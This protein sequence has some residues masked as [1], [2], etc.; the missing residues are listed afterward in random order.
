[1][2]VGPSFFCVARFLTP[3]PLILEHREC[4]RIKTQ[5]PSPTEHITPFTT[6]PRH[7]SQPMHDAIRLKKSRSP[8]RYV[9]TDV[10]IRQD[11]DVLTPEQR[12]T[13]YHDTRD[14]P[15][16]QESLAHFN[17]SQLESR[18]SWIPYEELTDIE[19]VGQGGVSTV[20]S[21]SYRTIKV[22]FK[23]MDPLLEREIIY[24]MITNVNRSSHLD[25]PINVIGLSKNPEKNKVLMVTEHA[26]GGSLDDIRLPLTETFCL[27]SH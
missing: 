13:L 1:M 25:S 27:N 16:L 8:V 9:Y 10:L 2:R 23:E 26:D 24:N 21:A 12:K 18:L 14:D 15:V 11:E 22:V 7:P 6:H 4:Q 19:C 3:K 20:Y 17:L 5:P